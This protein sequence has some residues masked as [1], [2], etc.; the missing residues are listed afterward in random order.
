M[1][2]GQQAA[3]C[4]EVGNDILITSS[5]NFC[6]EVVRTVIA[7]DTTLGTLTLNERIDPAVNLLHARVDTDGADMAVWR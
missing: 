1:H 4:W 6:G 3:T 2:V 5:S 7:R